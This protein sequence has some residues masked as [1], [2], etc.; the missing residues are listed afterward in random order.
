MT[1]TIQEV[2]ST[3]DA[4]EADR[5]II[6]ELLDEIVKEVGC[7]LREAGLN[8][9]VHFAVPTSGKGLVLLG[10]PLNPSDRDWNDI[11]KI[12]LPVISDKFGGVRLCNR[13]LD[14]ATTEMR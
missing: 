13:D 2:T 1:T 9:P 14:F 8:Y 12:V 6:R 4:F 7:R 5:E 11:T 10:T 3:D